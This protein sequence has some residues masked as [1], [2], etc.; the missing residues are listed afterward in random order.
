MA[1][2][3][4]NI[5]HLSNKIQG[6]FANHEGNGVLIRDLLFKPQVHFGY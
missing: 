3:Q 2:L 5:E 4:S 6:S 1:G